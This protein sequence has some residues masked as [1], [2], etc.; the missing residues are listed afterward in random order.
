MEIYRYGE[1]DTQNRH[2]AWTKLRTLN[3]CSSTHFVW[4]ISMRSQNN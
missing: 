1:P 3:R 2:E 4:V